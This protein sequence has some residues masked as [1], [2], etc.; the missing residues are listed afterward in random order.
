VLDTTVLQP[1]TNMSTTVRLSVSNKCRGELS[2][3]SDWAKGWRTRDLG[4]Q[5]Q[6]GQTAS[7]VSL[8]SPPFFAM[9]SSVLPG[10]TAVEA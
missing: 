10:G 8:G 3:H 2:Q 1:V 9:D 5:T 6:Q 7:I 4:F